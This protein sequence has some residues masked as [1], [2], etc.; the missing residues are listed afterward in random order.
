VPHFALLALDLPIRGLI[1]GL[2][3]RGWILKL[4]ISELNHT[5]P[6]IE[7]S[8]DIRETKTKLDFARILELN[9]LAYSLTSVS[10]QLLGYGANE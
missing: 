4:Q 1:V 2:S 7:V 6:R 10:I 8:I 9:R 3:K 5:D